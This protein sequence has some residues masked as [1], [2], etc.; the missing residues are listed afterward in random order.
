M[1]NFDENVKYIYI[2]YSTKHYKRKQLQHLLDL[3]IIIK[4][5]VRF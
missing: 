1:M 4:C 5:M 3:I 2:Y